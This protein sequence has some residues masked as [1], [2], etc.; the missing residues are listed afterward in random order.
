VN[1]QSVTT[2]HADGQAHARTVAP[3][4]SRLVNTSRSLCRSARKNSLKPTPSTTKQPAYISRYQIRAAYVSRSFG[5][6][7]L[8]SFPVLTAQATDKENDRA[9]PRHMATCPTSIEARDQVDGDKLRA[10]RHSKLSRGEQWLSWNITTRHN[11][12]YVSL[13]SRC[14]ASEIDEK[15][16]FNPSSTLR[17]SPGSDWQERCILVLFTSLIKSQQLLTSVVSAYYTV[18]FRSYEMN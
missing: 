18:A 10:A 5:V 13:M 14:L 17:F 9:W 12:H 16:S 2:T 8:L 4:R 6:S 11:A 15:Y 1:H 3:L 7:F